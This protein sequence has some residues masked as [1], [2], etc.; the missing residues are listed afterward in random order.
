MLPMLIIAIFTVS[1]TV[2]EMMPKPPLQAQM[3]VNLLVAFQKNRSRGSGKV[4]LGLLI[5]SAVLPRTAALKTRP[6]LL[7]EWGES[8]QGQIL[9]TVSGN[10]PFARS[11]AGMASFEGKLLVFGGVTGGGTLRILSCTNC[12]ACGVYE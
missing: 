7:Q 11:G 4:V 3:L 1:L 8:G 9:P 2:A 6:M 5:V 12:S 10:L